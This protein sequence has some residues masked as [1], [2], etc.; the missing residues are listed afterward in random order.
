[1][2]T[3][4]PPLSKIL[5]HSLPV[6][7]AVLH[8]GR[9]LTQALESV[10]GPYRAAVQD[11][12][13]HGLRHW[14]SLEALQKLMM[15]REPDEAEAGLLLKLALSLLHSS[16]STAWAPHYQAYTV[17]DQAVRTADRHPRL[18]RF[19][20]LINACLRRFLREQEVLEARAASSLEGRWNHPA[21][22][23]ERLQADHPQHWQDILQAAQ[24]PGPLTLR[25]NP[26]RATVGQVAQALHAVGIDS[27]PV[28]TQGLILHQA[29]PVTQLPGFAEGW[30]SVQDAGAQLAAELLPLK[31]GLRVLDAC[32]APG[33]K[34]AHILERADVDLTAL[35]VDAARLERVAQNLQ[36][37]GLHATLRQGDAAGDDWWD[38][39]GYDLILADVPCTASGI[40]RRH[41]DIRWLRRANDLNHTAA[42]QQHILQA[43]WSRL[44]PGGTLLYVTCSVF[45]LEGEAQAQAFAHHQADAQRLPAPGQLLPAGPD[46]PPSR[47]H[48]G[49]FYAMFTKA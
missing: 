7:A 14:G 24:A 13:F 27:T 43:L 38:G 49:F 45:H 4:A 47:Q 44:K 11:L 36:R 35:D 17:V 48:D 37:L 10:G 23:V 12:A 34:T 29:K 3:P 25:V 9:S 5:N 21:W 8:E 22:W 15:P 6:L 18:R 42:L 40:V 39:Q 46:T 20:N 1:M 26:R 31:D 28:H 32:A 41:P 30:W 19:K 16:T 33:G 2:N